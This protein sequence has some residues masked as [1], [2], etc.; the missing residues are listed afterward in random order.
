M[1]F[2]IDVVILFFIMSNSTLLTLVWIFA[3]GARL[4]AIT[5]LFVHVHIIPGPA[6]IANQLIMVEGRAPKLF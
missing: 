1:D 4:M 2:A 6:I 5:A 3:N